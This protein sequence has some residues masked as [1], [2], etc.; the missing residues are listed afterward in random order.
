MVGADA[1]DVEAATGPGADGRGALNQTAPALPAAPR[2]AVPPAVPDRR[3]RAARHG[4]DA[5]GRPRDRVRLRGDDAAQAFPT[6]PAVLRHR[7]DDALR[8]PEGEFAVDAGFAIGNL[9]EAA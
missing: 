6:L 1:E 8:R 7:Q 3:I 9:E 4:V 2:R 5:V